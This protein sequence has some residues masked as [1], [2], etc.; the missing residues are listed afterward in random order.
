MF[1][2]LLEL[3]A[4][5]L[6]APHVDS[7]FGIIMD[8]PPLGPDGKFPGGSGPAQLTQN[9]F[10][11]QQ[12]KAEAAQVQTPA[13]TDEL[14]RPH[15]DP[16]DQ[17][18]APSASQGSQPPADAAAPNQSETAKD[19]PKDDGKGAQKHDEGHEHS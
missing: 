1:S 11:P 10:A 18:A 12:A 4:L 3:P 5:F 15:N 2:F 13:N 8:P 14:R 9:V 17:G 16:T 7:F 19:S 6:I